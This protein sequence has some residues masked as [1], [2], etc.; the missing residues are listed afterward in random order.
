M[1]TSPKT[2]SP[3]GRRPR[4]LTVAL[5]ILWLQVLTNLGGGILFVVL[6][7]TE[8]EHGRDATLIGLGAALSL[9]AAPVLAAGAIGVARRAAWARTPVVVVEI[10]VILNGVVT[11]IVAFRDGLPP[12]GFL[13]IVLAFLVLQGIYSAETTAWLTGHAPEP[14]GTA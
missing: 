3:S 10:L 9:L 4:G 2:S 5:V 7:R 12:S 8:A 11:V 1:T 14:R 6:A 13:G